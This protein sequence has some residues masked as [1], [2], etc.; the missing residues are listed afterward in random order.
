MGNL[1]YGHT[2]PNPA[3]IQAGAEYQSTQRR[4]HEAEQDLAAERALRTTHTQQQHQHTRA[5]PHAD[6]RTR[7]PRYGRDLDD[8]GDLDPE[9]RNRPFVHSADD[10]QQFAAWERKGELRAHKIELFSGQTDLEGLLKW[11]RSVEHYGC[12][13]GFSEE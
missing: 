10:S 9:E 12:L 6:R 5:P 2:D 1:G 4:L 11:F 8:Y 3:R 7:Q 13:A